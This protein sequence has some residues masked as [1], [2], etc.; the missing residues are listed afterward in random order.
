MIKADEYRKKEIFKRFFTFN[1]P[2]S[3]PNCDDVTAV[4]TDMQDNIT[5]IMKGEVLKSFSSK[6]GK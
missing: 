6:K 1:I 4:I 3:F 2:D 5:P